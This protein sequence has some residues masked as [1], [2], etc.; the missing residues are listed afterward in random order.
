[1]KFSKILAAASV[2]ALTILSS[3]KNKEENLG[4]AS[5]SVDPT[6]ISLEAASESR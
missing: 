5:I 1:M 2:A 6:E 3:C 4:A